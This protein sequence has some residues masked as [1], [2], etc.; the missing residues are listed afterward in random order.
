MKI[1]RFLNMKFLVLPMCFLLT[2]SAAS[3]GSTVVFEKEYTYQAS[4]ADSKL[5]CRTIAL[6]QVK[7]LLL[8]E[9]GTYLE[10]QTEVKNFQLA[11]DQITTLTAGIVRAEIIDEKWDGKI[12]TL[13]AKITADPNEVV[14]QIDALR[15]DR[16]KARELEDAKKRADE[17]LKEVERLKGE[18]EAA[19]G[20]KKQEKQREYAD[21]INGLNAADWF[22]KGFSLLYDNYNFAIA[23]DAFSKCIELAPKFN[24]LCYQARGT[25]NFVLGYHRQAVDDFDKSIEL[26]IEG[27]TPYF[28][29]G[30]AYAELGDSR[31]ALKDYEKALKLKPENVERVYDLRGRA[32]AALRDYRQAIQDYN[33]AL[34]LKPTYATAYL[35]RA[36]AYNALGKQQ[37]AIKDFSKAIEIDDKSARAYSG[38]G[39]VYAELGNYRQAIDDYDR[40]IALNIGEARPPE[41]VSWQEVMADPEFQAQPLEVKQRVAKN[42]FSRDL[43]TL[44]GAY[45]LRGTAF[46][47]LGNYQKAITDYNTAIEMNPNDALYYY[48]RGDT[49]LKFDNYQLAIKDFDKAIEMASKAKFYTMRGFAYF[50]LSNYQQAITDYDKAIQ[51][52]PANTAAY[53]FRAEAYLGLGNY[54]QAIRDYDKAITEAKTVNPQ[55]YIGRGQAY[56]MLGNRRQAIKDLNKAIERNPAYVQAYKRRGAI[57]AVLNDFQRAIKDY[58]KAIELEP[59]DAATY[60]SL[61]SVYGKLGHEQQAIDNVKIA[62]RLGLKEAQ[63]LL[64]QN[65][66]EW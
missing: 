30:Q 65:G 20:D 57:Y 16:Q 62:A 37:Q 66:I 59:K 14:K 64:K 34:S 7:R 28:W 52:E 31:N 13:K 22:E 60:I 23:A 32:Y 33:K 45:I 4:E 6:E 50:K 49:H 25:A 55:A 43:S 2:S 54:Q 27:A 26:G 11:K 39:Y 48:N 53:L 51:I 46:R 17:L 1:I 44:A 9:L 36:F 19:K 41:R 15:K 18:I 8:E 47:E 3:A 40:S 38:R 56:F 42:Y 12:Y 63:E 21:T 24:M 58:S 35:N 29:R 61:A 5:S 10:G